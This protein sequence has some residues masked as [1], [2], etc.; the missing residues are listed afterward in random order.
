MWLV[1]HIYLSIF[2]NGSYSTEGQEVLGTIPGG[3]WQNSGSFN[4]SN[5]Y[6][7]AVLVSP[8]FLKNI[9]FYNYFMA[10]NVTNCHLAGCCSMGEVKGQM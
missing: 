2:C 10:V 5:G 8:W 3:F 1:V 7:R 6:F 9:E 4:Y